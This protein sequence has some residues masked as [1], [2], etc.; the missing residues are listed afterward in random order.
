MILT[1]EVKLTGSPTSL[2]LEAVATELTLLAIHL[3]DA[4][5]SAEI[6][7]QVLE[8]VC[9]VLSDSPANL[10]STLRYLTERQGQLYSWS[11]QLRK[12]RE[13]LSDLVNT[14]ENR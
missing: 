7:Y 14:R 3:E 4:A 10:D 5:R 12:M 1:E 13:Q 2:N 6:Q 11:N 9:H 8:D